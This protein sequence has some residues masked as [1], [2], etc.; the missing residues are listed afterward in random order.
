MRTF[1]P[2]RLF[3][4]ETF[5]MTPVIDVVFLLI[6]FF[7]LVAQFIVAEQYEVNV[8]DQIKTA[9][10]QSEVEAK[11]PLTITVLLGGDEAVTCAVGTDKL[12]GVK[13]SDIEKLVT[14]TINEYL[15]SQEPVDKTVRLRCDRAVPFGEVKYILAGISG[16]RAQSLDWAVLSE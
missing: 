14:S 11:K 1:K 7:M 8:P 15:S 3:E 10:E 5:D 2:R 16:S 12:T 6:I 4:L 13:G 9:Q